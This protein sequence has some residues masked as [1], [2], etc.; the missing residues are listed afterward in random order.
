MG[1]NF[2]ENYMVAR[3]N[4]EVKHVVMGDRGQEKHVVLRI[5]VE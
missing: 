4:V 5:N 3:S 2:H 1:E